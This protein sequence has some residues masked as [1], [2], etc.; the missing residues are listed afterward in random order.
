MEHVCSLGDEDEATT[1]GGYLA[2]LQPLLGLPGTGFE[3]NPSAWH[4][5]MFQSDVQPLEQ[6]I[7]QLL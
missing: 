4:P 5:R 3:G 2:K 6:E 1:P 7:K